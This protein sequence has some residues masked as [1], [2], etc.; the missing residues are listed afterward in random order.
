MGQFTMRE[1]DGLLN[2]DLTV[3]TAPGR[4]TSVRA[5]IP[6][7]GRVSSSSR[8]AAGAILSRT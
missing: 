1:R 2:G 5:S 8:A 4:G 6:V 7:E 3:E